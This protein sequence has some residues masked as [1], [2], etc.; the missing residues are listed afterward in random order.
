MKRIPAEAALA[1]SADVDSNAW[2]PR[3]AMG[4]QD[5][6]QRT[7]GSTGHTEAAHEAVHEVHAEAVAEAKRKE[8]AQLKEMMAGY[9]ATGTLP[10]ESPPPPPE[11]PRPPEKSPL[12][13][14]QSTVR[15]CHT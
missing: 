15:P 12:G 13:K 7:V 3:L 14:L 5:G 6:G 2:V 4:A 10:A 1:A 8:A 9:M 11:R